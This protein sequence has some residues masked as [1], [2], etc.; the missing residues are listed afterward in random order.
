[1]ERINHVP[2]QLSDRAVLNDHIWNVK[3]AMEGQITRLSVS[4]GECA[5]LGGH[6]GGPR[7]GHCT[8]QMV[9]RSED[10]HGSTNRRKPAWKLESAAVFPAGAQ[11]CH[12]GGA[13]PSSPTSTAAA[14]SGSKKAIM[15]PSDGPLKTGVLQGKQ[16]AGSGVR[17][18][19]GPPLTRLLLLSHSS[20]YCHNGGMA[21]AH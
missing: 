10:P 7:A 15:V 2:L 17:A 9:E 14:G 20:K 18:L 5:R 12:N 16:P 8:V 11:D 19:W 1:M 6:R 13:W 3:I 21:F 4:N